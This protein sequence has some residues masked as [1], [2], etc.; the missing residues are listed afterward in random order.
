M[1]VAASLA[2]SDSLQI[3]LQ[4]LPFFKS[5]APSPRQFGINDVIEISSRSVMNLLHSP[6]SRLHTLDLSG[7]RLDLNGGATNE[8]NVAAWADAALK[9]NRSLRYFALAGVR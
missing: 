3:R 9:Q 5:G 7:F 6:A 4:R 1:A 8:L 2:R